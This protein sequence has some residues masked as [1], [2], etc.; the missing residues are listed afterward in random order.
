MSKRKASPPEAAP[1]AKEEAAPITAEGDMPQKKYYRSRAHCNPL[2]HN[3]GFDYPVR[4]SEMDWSGH[5]PSIADPSVDFVDVGCGFG[6]LTVALATLFPDKLTLAMEIRPKVVE[7][8]R[9]R[10]AALRKENPGQYGNVAALKTNA[11]RYL[12]NFFRKGQLTKLFFCFPD[13]HFKTKNHRRRIVSP[14]LL[15]EY[16]Y[17]L[18]EGALLYTVTDVKELHDW[19][20]VRQFQ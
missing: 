6:G 4:P 9:L 20:E 2:S 10:I 18:A 17:I 3:D 8:V 14:N 19:M 7:Y 13:P 11:M 5:Y 12:P 16:A 1:E 15:H